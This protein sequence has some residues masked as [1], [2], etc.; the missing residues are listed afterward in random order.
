MIKMLE[1]FATITRLERGNHQPDSSFCVMEAVAYVAGEPWSDAPECACPVL[2]AYC[3]VLNDNMN[4]AERQALLPFVVRLIG[5]RIT[6]ENEQQRAFVLADAA[7][8]I[9]APLALEAGGLAFE[10]AKLRALPII[11]SVSSAKSARRAARRAAESAAKITAHAARS[12]AE[13]A[14]NA[15]KSATE[16][17]VWSAESVAWSAESA[18]NAARS[19][20]KSAVESATRSAAA[21]AARSAANA[22]RSA[23]ESVVW[24]AALEVLDRLLITSSQAR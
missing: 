18:S 9:F 5:T 19:A 22:A 2:A 12:A 10:A 11:D 23:A 6:P 20:T 3:R 17:V 21:S 8:R 7:V 24:I 14:S 16:S 4:D 13:S 15:A 1:R